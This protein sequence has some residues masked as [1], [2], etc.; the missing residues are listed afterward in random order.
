MANQ[1]LTKVESITSSFGGNGALD[2]V[3]FKVKHGEILGLIGPS[4]VGKT[5]ILSWITMFYRPQAE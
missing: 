5:S 2:H 4:G 3:N 1:E